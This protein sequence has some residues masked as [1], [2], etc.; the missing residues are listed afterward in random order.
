MSS[1]ANALGEQLTGAT[2][3][4]QRA[5]WDSFAIATTTAMNTNATKKMFT[6]NVVDTGGVSGDVSNMRLAGMLPAGHSHMV[7]AIRVEMQGTAADLLSFNQLTWLKFFYSGIQV[8]E[9]TIALLNGGVGMSGSPSNGVADA[10]SI[11]Y[12]DKQPIDV[13]GMTP[14]RFE[15][16]TG[17]T[18]STTAAFFFRA[19]LDGE[20]TEPA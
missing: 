20:Y 5:L 12:F 17:A 4:A 19:Y 16:N 2:R 13:Q 10:R 3:T 9:S 6:T 11:Y 15:V 8:F 18:G 7:R 14:F 1:S